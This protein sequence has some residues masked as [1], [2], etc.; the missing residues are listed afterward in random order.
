MIGRSVARF[1]DARF[2]TGRGRYVADVMVPGAAHAYVLR[3]PHA[4]AVIERIEIEA[5][6]AAS[7]VLA[8]ATEADL[9]AEGLGPLPCVA[10]V[11]SVAPLIVPPRF[12]LARGRVRH[13]GDPV[14]LVVA[15]TRDMAHDAAERIAVEYR[16]LDAVVDAKTALRPG[17][18]RIWDE[19]PGN[20][21]FRFERGER[22]KV[23]AAFA[24]A[25]HLVELELVNNRVVPAPI[26]PRAAL[27]RWDESSQS[28][29][30]LLTGQGVH[31]IRQQLAG[32]VLDMPP[33][34]IRL[35]APDVGGGFGMK[36]FLYP[37]WVLLLWAAR[38]LRRPV[39]WIGERGEEF[40]AATHGRDNH[41]RARLAL[42]ETGRFLALEVATI[43]NLG[44]YL[45]SNGPG[46]ST[47]SP[48]TAM[49]GVYAIPAVF[50]AVQGA[51]TNTAP[52]DA[53]RGAGKPEAN[54]LIERLVDLAAR[55]IGRDPME[56][57]RR[58]MIAA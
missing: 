25:A 2:L 10:Q 43:A 51:F 21:C 26:E 35:A 24:G 31:S 14:A 29:D 3:S 57:R 13:V 41:T 11:A 40:A 33:E 48:A 52:V 16:P 27:G 34:R 45:S 54:Y 5:A 8:V 19:A 37:E 28:F 6:R 58:N 32:S 44:A 23:A 15:E 46:S 22:E 53:Y 1:E 30:L 39:K 20:L 50:M 7:G 47:N 38:R 17:A 49:G 36:N 18:A 56:L 4:H 12:A 42:D 55:R 9:A